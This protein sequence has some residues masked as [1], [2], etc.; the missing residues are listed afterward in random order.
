MPMGLLWACKNKAKGKLKNHVINYLLT[1]LAEVVRGI[2]ALSCF[3]TD[4]AVLGLYCQDL[5]PIFPIMVWY[6][7]VVRS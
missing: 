3:L 7:M 5:G 6:G 4:L 1:E 2:L